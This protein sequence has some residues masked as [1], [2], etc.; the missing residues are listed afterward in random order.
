MPH[1]EQEA[2]CPRIAASAKPNAVVLHYGIHQPRPYTRRGRFQEVVLLHRFVF[3]EGS[4]QRNPA[5]DVLFGR[6]TQGKYETLRLVVFRTT[7]SLAS[8]VTVGL[9]SSLIPRGT[10]RSDTDFRCRSRLRVTPH[11]LP[12]CLSGYERL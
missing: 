3:Q 6:F 9:I 12:A 5:R 4:R 8:G 11:A 7:H 10:Q 2:A 1:V